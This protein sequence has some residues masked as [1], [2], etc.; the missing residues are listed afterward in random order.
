MVFARNVLTGAGAAH[1]EGTDL[2]RTLVSSVTVAVALMVRVT[3]ITCGL[4]AAP[5]V[6][7]VIAPLCTPAASP[8]GLTETCS[9]AGEVPA[10]GVTRSQVA[11]AEAD[12]EKENAPPEMA[13]DCAAGDAP[14]A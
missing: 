7:T 10:A 2:V 3:A 9:E 14:P 4:F 12:A 8:P 1:P 13:T 6:V 5:A 11:A